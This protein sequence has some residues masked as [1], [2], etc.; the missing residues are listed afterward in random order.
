MIK[1]SFLTS[2][3]FSMYVMDPRGIEEVT[4]T[5]FKLTV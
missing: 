1:R 2:R 4:D 3:R 5:D